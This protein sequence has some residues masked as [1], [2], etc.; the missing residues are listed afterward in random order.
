LTES[1]QILGLNDLKLADLEVK[2][3]DLVHKVAAHLE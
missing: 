3:E 2:C 1:A